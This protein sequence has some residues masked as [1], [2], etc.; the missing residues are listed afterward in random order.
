MA[1]HEDQ[2]PCD[3]RHRAYRQRNA[4][5]QVKPGEEQRSDAGEQR[6]QHPTVDQWPQ[7]LARRELPLVPFVRVR[8]Y[9]VTVT[10]WATRGVSPGGADRRRVKRKKTSEGAGMDQNDAT[11]R[12]PTVLALVGS[13]RRQGNTVFAVQ[14]AAEELA[15]RGVD[16]ESVLLCDYMVRLCESDPDRNECGEEDG[17]EVL[18]DRVWAAD[19]L[20]LATPIHFCTVSAQMKAFMDRT[21][22]RFLRQQWLAPKAVGLMAIGGQGGFTDTINT[23]R[24]YLELIAPSGPPTAV[25]TG[26]ADA[27]GEAQQSDEVRAAALTMAARMADILLP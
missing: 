2:P 18:L 14:V 25:A 10:G 3:D 13:P 7:D 8:G 27:V 15:R 1:A 19:G 20:I 6:A 26:H 16:C 4:G 9:Y 11:V 17:A 22:D 21:N 12:R 24:R 23:M 5:G